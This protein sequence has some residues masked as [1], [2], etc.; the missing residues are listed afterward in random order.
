MEHHIGFVVPD[1]DA[2]LEKSVREG[3]TILKE[4]ADEPTQ[5]VK[6]AFVLPNEATI[7]LELVAPLGP[8]SPVRTRLNHGGG[9]DHIAY[10][11]DDI[12]A[13]IQR[14]Q[15]QGAKLVRPPMLAINLQQ[16]VAFVYRR[17]GLM[18]EFV[19]RKPFEPKLF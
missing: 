8:N 9:L 3:C 18:I 19:E 13:R 16:R 7:P 1:L 5:G 12:E 6:V 10:E 17:S 14:E 15:S 4:A 11:T 2:A